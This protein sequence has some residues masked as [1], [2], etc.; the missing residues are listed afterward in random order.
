MI[1]IINHAIN[2]IKKINRST[3]LK[4]SNHGQRNNSLPSTVS[5]HLINLSD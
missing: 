4:G 2:A 5:V 1:K 3:A